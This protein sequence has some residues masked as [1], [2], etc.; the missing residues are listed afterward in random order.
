MTLKGQ[1]AGQQLYVAPGGYPERQAALWAESRP[2]DADL[3]R[4]LA[5]HPQVRWFGR[6]D[7]DKSNS[8]EWAAVDKHLDA[9]QAAEKVAAIALYWMVNR[10]NGSYSK[11]GAPDAPTYRGWVGTI[12]DAIRGRR[13][14]VQ[15]EADSL[16]MLDRIPSSQ[17]QERV[18]LLKFANEKISASGAEVYVDCGS[19]NWLSVAEAVRRLKLVGA[20]R[21]SLNWSGTQWVAD[22]SAYAQ[23]IRGEMGGDIRWI[24]DTSRC[25]LGP[26]EA[27]EGEDPDVEWLNSPGRG[28]GP[29]PTLNVSQTAHPGCDAWLYGKTVGTSDGKD[30]RGHPEAG[31]WMPEEALG[32]IKRARPVFSRV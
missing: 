12:A 23:A 28:C 15:L 16:A 19:S 31:E 8:A 3:M 27:K 17:Q 14:I 26:Y 11:G 2:A 22:E 25:G 7:G 18:D 30:D 24:L 4:R 21:F 13:C 20:T 10:D 9:A 5:A 29:R 1:F 6:W 32:L